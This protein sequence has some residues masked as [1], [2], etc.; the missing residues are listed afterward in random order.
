MSG[1]HGKGYEIL[2]LDEVE[3]V[4]YH[5]R[6]GQKLLTVD[7]LLGYRIAG[8]NGWVGDPGERL[9]PEH[10]EDED[11]EL[12]V[13]VRGRATFTV[14]GEEVD[15]PAG[16]LVHLV[17][18]ERRA[19][20]SEAPGTIVLAIGAEPGK[21]H[22]P[23]G[24]THWV[25]ADALR[26]DGRVDEGRAAIDEMLR[27]HP[28][29]WFA[30]YNAACYEALAGDRDRAFEH[31]SRAV[32]LNRTETRRHGGEDPDLETLRSDPRWQEVVG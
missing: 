24:W 13:V 22:E 9:V 28:G 19:A 32:R 6:E 29:S 10:E 2:S 27:A 4:P 8:V 15:A 21:A 30:P 1:V 31:L 25:V 17:A 14:A 26:R 20:V 11:E 18:G 23:S 3:P 5:A 7:R 12:Y 16:T